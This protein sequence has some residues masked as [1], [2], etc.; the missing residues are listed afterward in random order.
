MPSEEYRESTLEGLHHRIDN[1]KCDLLNQINDNKAFEKSLI[2]EIVEIKMSL[3]VMSR[4]FETLIN[5]IQYITDS[6]DFLS[7]Q[8]SDLDIDKI[9]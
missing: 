8:I 3:Y 6:V 4:Q 7:Q 1:V 5:K 2:N 9:E